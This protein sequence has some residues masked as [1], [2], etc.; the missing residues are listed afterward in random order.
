MQAVNLSWNPIYTKEVLATKN[1]VRVLP[2]K[3]TS[4]DM[5][6]YV[7][8]TFAPGPRSILLTLLDLPEP[9]LPLQTSAAKLPKLPRLATQIMK[10]LIGEQWQALLDILQGRSTESN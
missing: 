8:E 2:S 7:Y 10:R 9:R 5:S 1:L 3:A 4:F 6:S